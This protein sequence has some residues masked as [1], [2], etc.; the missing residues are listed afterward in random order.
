MKNQYFGDVNDYQKYGLLRILSGY[1]ALKTGVC[2]ML[3]ANDGRSNGKFVSYL[4]SPL[5]WRGFDPELYDSLSRTVK[6]DKKRQVGQ[7]EIRGILPNTIFYEKL[8]EDDAS[9][10]QDYFFNTLRYFED[11]DLIFFDPDNGLEIKSSKRGRKNSCKFLFWDEVEDAF[12]NGH[13]VLI[14]QHFPRKERTGFIKRISEELGSRLVV[15]EIFSFKTRNVVF[16]LVP[17]KNNLS[18]FRCQTNVVEKIWGKEIKNFA[19]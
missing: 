19:L 3:T 18:H 17:Q 2:W 6:I 1:G 14:Y 12:N 8:L 9:Q 10:R 16:F 5:K 15:N 11:V 4:D 13:S 7:A